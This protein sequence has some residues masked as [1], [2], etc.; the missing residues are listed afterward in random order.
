MTAALEVCSYQLVEGPHHDV[1]V[2]LHD[3]I[4]SLPE[5]SAIILGELKTIAEQYLERSV[6]KCV[7]TVPAYFN[8]GQRQATKD[9]GRIAGLDVIRMINEPTAAALAYGHGKMLSSRIAVFDLGGGTFDISILE[10]SGGVFEVRAT[11]GDTYLGGE[12]FDARILE[13]LAYRFLSEH[14]I[15]LRNDRLA[16]QRLRD[17]VENAKIELSSREQVEINLP[18]LVAGPNDGALHMQTVL[19]RHKLEALVADV[20]LRCIDICKRALR[21]A[22]LRKQDIDDVII[23]GGQTRTPYLQRLVKSFFER[24]PSRSV[25]PDEAVALGAAIQATSL[26]DHN[27]S[28]L[29]LD[30][31]PHDLGIMI[32]GGFFQT[33]IERNTTVPSSESHR[34]TTVRDHQTSVRIVVFQG[35]SL[36]AIENEMLGEFTLDGLRAAPRGRGRNRGDLQ[37]IVRWH[38]R[39]RGGRPGDG[40]EAADHRDGDLTLDRGRDPPH[41]ARPVARLS[42][43]PVEFRRPRPPTAATLI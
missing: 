35:E 43:R 9:A 21:E 13:W 15:D 26:V 30:V 1:R 20:C 36:Q 6:D 3:V 32:I 37:H 23:V 38:R 5:I 40:A 39:R 31:T 18:F 12:D 16:L 33:I 17:A 29:L 41:D 28:I 4:Y 10:I 25:N 24:E 27:S 19:T 42:I 14:Q 34:F 22:K 2:A 11:A 8:D 7:L